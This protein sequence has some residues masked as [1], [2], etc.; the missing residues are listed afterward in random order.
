LHDS[1]DKKPIVVERRAISEA[2]SPGTVN[3]TQSAIVDA[4]IIA[5]ISPV[6]N[7]KEE[8]DPDMRQA[9]NGNHWHRGMTG[10]IGVTI[11]P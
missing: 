9:K 6:K 2:E 7:H 5:A 1:K 3:D 10:N 8:C 4:P 11:G